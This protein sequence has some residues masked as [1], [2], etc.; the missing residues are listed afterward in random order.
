MKISFIFYR[1]RKRSMFLIPVS[2]GTCETTG[3]WYLISVH[4]RATGTVTVPRDL[5][6]KAPSATLT[7]MRL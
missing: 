2:K 1:L 6:F 4:F 5:R 3:T 7:V